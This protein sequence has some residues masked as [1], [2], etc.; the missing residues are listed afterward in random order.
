MARGTQR[1]LYALVPVLAVVLVVVGA[2]VL[3]PSLVPPALRRGLG[4]APHRVVAARHVPARG[5]FG[6][7][8]VQADGRS[9]VGYDPCREVRFLVDPLRAPAG[10]RD[11]VLEA[12]DHAGAAA[13]L[14]LVYAGTTDERPHWRSGTKV[15]VLFGEPRSRPVLISWAEPSEVPELDGPVAGVGGSVAAGDSSGSAHYVTGGITLDAGVYADLET[16]EGGR[17]HERAILLHELGHVLGLDHVDDEAEL[18]DPEP[19]A[20]DYGPGDLAGLARVGS[21]PCA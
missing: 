6:F 12:L 3:A 13:G 9:P 15:P 10:Y 1:D 8:A 20:L 2:L 5:T 19:T 11:L 17:A 7:L 21:T 14:R 4:L 18:M 16:E